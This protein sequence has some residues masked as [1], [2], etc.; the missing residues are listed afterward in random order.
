[1][2]TAI[3]GRGGKVQINGTP[4]YTV[5][6]IESWQGTVDQQLYD[7][8]SLGDTWTSD[9]AGF[10]TLTGTIT[11]KWNVTTDAGQTALHNAVLNATTVG[12]YLSVDGSNGYEGTFNIS[13]FQTSD[14]VNGLVTFSCSFRNTGQI[15]FN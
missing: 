5:A 6:L 14:P 12:L 4:A 3:A 13:N 8:T 1:M 7:Q 10:R 11:G 9:V 2:A 15:F